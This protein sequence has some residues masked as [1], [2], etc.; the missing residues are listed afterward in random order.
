MLLSAI[1]STEMIFLL[2]WFIIQNLHIQI[3][4]FCT[5]VTEAEKGKKKKKG[6]VLAKWPRIK[7][8]VEN[9][10]LQAIKNFLQT[11]EHL[12]KMKLKSC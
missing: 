10:D 3:S 5:G 8:V 9:L 11:M 4:K 2:Q 12:N 6:P 7:L 1:P